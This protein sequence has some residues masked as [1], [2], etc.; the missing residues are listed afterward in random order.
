[1]SAPRPPRST[2]SPSP[3]ESVLMPSSPVRTSL[4]PP[5]VRFSMPMNTSSSV[6]RPVARSAVTEVVRPA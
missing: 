5:P 2:S 3:P 1:M 4:P 6:L